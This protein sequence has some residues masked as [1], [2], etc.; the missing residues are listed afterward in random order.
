MNQTARRKTLGLG[1]SAI[2]F[3]CGPSVEDPEP[4]VEL[5]ERRI[6]PCRTECRIVLDPECG[7][8][9]HPNFPMF[10]SVE[11]CI[12]ECA[13]TDSVW[14][15][16]PQTDGTDACEGEWAIYSSC[17]AALSCEEQN[18]HWTTSPS[19]DAPCKQESRNLTSCGS[20]NPPPQEGG[21]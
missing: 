19:E 17:M 8:T 20:D 9:D 13:K 3:G 2:V 11:S 10:E 4:P 14:H 1:L 12:E 7:N 16:G 15:W 5:V 6:E 18:R 21:S